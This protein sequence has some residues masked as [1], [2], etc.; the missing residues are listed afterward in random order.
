MKPPILGYG[1]QEDLKARASLQGGRY[2]FTFSVSATHL[3]EEDL[4]YSPGEEVPFALCKA[5]VLTRDA[6]LPSYNDP[7]ELAADLLKPSSPCAPEPEDVYALVRHLAGDAYTSSQIEALKDLAT[8]IE[9][10]GGIISLEGVEDQS[11]RI[12]NL[13]SIAEDLYQSSQEKS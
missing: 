2:W 6:Y 12:E 11:D 3:F 4:E 5:H 7:V 10:R 13:Q 9:R 1:S 8:E